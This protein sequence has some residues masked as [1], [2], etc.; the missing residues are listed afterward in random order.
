[1]RL[2]CKKNNETVKS[3]KAGQTK[4]TVDRSTLWTAETP[5][6]FN[7]EIL[8]DAYDRK[9]DISMNIQMKLR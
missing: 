3:V 7:Q 6:V 4:F 5:Q 9:L 2:S 1:M 8:H